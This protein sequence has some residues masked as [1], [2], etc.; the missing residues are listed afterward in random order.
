MAPITKYY[1]RAGLG[2]EELGNMSQLRER[3][4]DAAEASPALK[5]WLSDITLLR[6]LRA[7]SGN[8]DKA[9][10][11]LRKTIA[12]RKEMRPEDIRW[13][14]VKEEARPGKL[15]VSRHQDR[16][17][18]HVLVMRPRNENSKD[19]AGNIRNLVYMMET[20]CFL[21]DE[22]ESVQ[23]TIVQDFEGYG[24][25]N[26]PPMKTSRETLSI[27]QGHYPERPQ[28]GTAL[29]GPDGLQLLLEGHLPLHRPRHL[30]EGRLC[31]QGRQGGRG[32]G[33]P[34]RPS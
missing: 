20:I 28:G 15:F 3:V 9:E 23:I 31:G 14:D 21:A 33:S 10:E 17:G 1:D 6:Y 24:M 22:D 27:L 12:W 25:R 34:L 19:H 2:E 26:A 8:L 29:P 30:Q 32:H 16:S 5:K 7:R 11:M 4:Q 13:A 18:R